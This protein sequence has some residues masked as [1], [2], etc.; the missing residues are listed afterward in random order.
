MLHCNMKLAW[1]TSH[2]L[3][4]FQSGRVVKFD[5]RRRRG[6]RLQRADEVARGRN[7]K[8][9]RQR[10]AIRP[11]FEEH[12]AQRVLAVDMNRMRD[13]AGFGARAM[14]VLEAE[15]FDLFKTILPRR[16]AS[17]HYDHVRPRFVALLTAREQLRPQGPPAAAANVLVRHVRHR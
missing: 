10:D 6:E 13:A 15:F 8:M 7:C 4:L 12:R 1:Q 14:D 16:H 2:A 17:G 5:G 3:Q 9:R 11:L